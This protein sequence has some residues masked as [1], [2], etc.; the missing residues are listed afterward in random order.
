MNNTDKNVPIWLYSEIIDKMLVVIDNVDN[1]TKRHCERV[2]IYTGLFLSYLKKEN[3]WTDELRDLKVNDL[4]DIVYSAF[5]HDIGKAAIHSDITKAKRKLTE[6][7][8]TQ[9]K[10]HPMNGAYLFLLPGY[11]QIKNNILMHHERYSGNGYPFGLFGKD[12]PLGARIIAIADSFD[13][14]TD[15]RPYMWGPLTK[16]EALDELQKGI[17]KDYDPELTSLFIQMCNTPE[18]SNLLKIKENQ[19]LMDRMISHLK[20][21]IC[22]PEEER[23]LEEENKNDILQ[24]VLRKE[25]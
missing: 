19:E 5:V 11:G 16:E 9:M 25:Y 15:K 14:M 10:E 7:E 12:I 2:G 8:W 6:E 13:A 17:A 20:Q 22:S 24:K 4:K 18:Y 1:Y 3:L 23:F 21:W